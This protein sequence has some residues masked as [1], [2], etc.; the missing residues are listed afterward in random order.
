MSK[1]K[2]LTGMEWLRDRMETLE[3]HSLQEVAEDLGINR[4][5]LYRYFTLQTKPSIAMMPPLSEVLN[6][7]WE[8][9]LVAL[10]VVTPIR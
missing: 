4:G 10:E 5:N 3:Y 9:I 6:A 7:T 8:E 2:Y 1:K